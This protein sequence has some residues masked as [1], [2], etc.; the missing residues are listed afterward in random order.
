MPVPALPIPISAPQ[1]R[2]FVAG[3]ESYVKRICR[4]WRVSGPDV[5]D[6]VQESLAEIVASVRTFQPEKA[7]FE[8][9]ARGVARNVIRHYL[10]DTTSYLD[11]FSPYQA[12][13]EELPSSQ[14]SPERCAQRA[15]ARYAIVNAA[16]KGKPQQ[17]QVVVLHA[18]DGASHKEIGLQLQISAANSEKCFFRG[19][20]H[21][22]ECLSSDLLCAVPPSVSGC[23]D[24]SNSFAET[25]SFERS[26]YAGQI[27]AG[28]LA[29]L[30]LTLVGSRSIQHETSG[31]NSPMS[32]RD[33]PSVV[34]D[35]PAVHRDAP[36]GK[37]EPASLP[38]VPVV[39]KPTRGADKPAYVLDLAPLPPFKPTEHTV[40][41][42]PR[43]R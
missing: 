4:Q 39:P 22:A 17:M 16:E 42:R 36:A 32:Q 28:V 40:S 30:T 26:H 29:L 1:Q 35:E 25:R 5:E 11:C 7:D 23:D 14:P 2:T 19:L 24:K 21:F 37:L 43:G 34:H 10:R 6:L 3:I 41:H 31:Q 13:V 33:K 15:Q 27:V 8:T 9:W 38:S 12:N 20:T 18:I